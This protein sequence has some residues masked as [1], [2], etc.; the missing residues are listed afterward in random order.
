MGV[1]INSARYRQVCEGDGPPVV[2]GDALLVGT[3]L[4]FCDPFS[5]KDDIELHACWVE[6]SMRVINRCLLG[7]H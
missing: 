7:V 3:V 1:T 4:V 5:L 6:T 2:A